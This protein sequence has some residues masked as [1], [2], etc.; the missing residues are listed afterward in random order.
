M[1]AESGHSK[2]FSVNKEASKTF[3]KWTD[4]QTLFWGTQKIIIM[5]NKRAFLKKRNLRII[6]DLWGTASCQFQ[7]G[8]QSSFAGRSQRKKFPVFSS[9]W[10]SVKKGHW[11]TGLQSIDKTKSITGWQNPNF[12]KYWKE[13][14]ISILKG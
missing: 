14:T 1:G 5:I 7:Y 11:K 13:W 6:D 4:L 12:Y 9:K 8:I 2:N 10:T 3:F